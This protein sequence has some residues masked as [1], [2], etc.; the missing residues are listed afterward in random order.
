MSTDARPRLLDLFCG[1][2]GAG[3]GYHRAGFDVTGVDMAPQPRYPFAFVQADALE[4]LAEHGHEY[5]AIHASPPCQRHSALGAFYDRAQHPD[6]VGATR[7]ALQDLGRPWVIENVPGAPLRDA[8]ILCGSMF[9]LG[10]QCRDGAYHQLRRHRLFESSVFLLAPPCAHR[11][12]PVGVYGNGGG[13]AQRPDEPGPNGFVGTAQE[14]RDA[15]GIDWMDRYALSQAIPPAYTEWIAGQIM[16]S[17]D[18]QSI[19]MAGAAQ[20]MSGRC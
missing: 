9:G 2:G 6:L 5:D 13:R 16:R 20:G 1:A 12:R 17:H 7:D 19:Q 11:G 3:M 18:A 10:A 15:M 8:F 14:S 4:Y